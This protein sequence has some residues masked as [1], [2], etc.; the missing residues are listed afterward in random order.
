MS[1]EIPQFARIAID[2]GHRQVVHRYLTHGKAHE[3]REVAH[4]RSLGL[5]ESIQNNPRL[6]KIMTE[7]F[8]YE[9]PILETEV[10]TV[11]L[12]SPIIM[13]AGFDKRAEIHRFLGEALGF[14]AVTV[15]TITKIPY[16]GNEHPRIFDLANSDGL[17][18]RMGFPGDGSDKG[19]E[20]LQK[21]NP[22]KRK[23]KLLVSV[24]ASKPSFENGTEIEDFVS[25]STQLMPYGEGQEQNI[26]SPNTPGVTGLQKRYAELAS[27]LNQEVY[28]PYARTIGN[29][30]F[31][32]LVKVSPDLSAQDRDTLMKIGIHNGVNAYVLGN[33]T[34]DSGIKANLDSN[35]ANRNEQGGVSGQPL[36]EKAL[37]NSH[38]AYMLTGGETPIIMAGGI[39]TAED[40]WNAMTYGG[41]SAVELYTAFVRPNSS[42]PNLVYYLSK[43]LAKVMRMVGM[44]GME[45]FKMLRGK[46]LPYP[47]AKK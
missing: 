43:D 10:G 6:M 3:D 26:S 27:A 15:G 9:D 39:K 42:T 5:M 25:V 28:I 18:N 41:A 20:E 2:I 36:K 44:Q 47:L 40:V 4:T 16:G 23:Y 7:L 1:V 13:A 46:R 30:D 19:E 22:S 33:T 11:R 29:R 35:D 8:V 37:E 12:P 17:I 14:G 45:D 24:G 31:T 34:V 38:Q 21:D 32:I